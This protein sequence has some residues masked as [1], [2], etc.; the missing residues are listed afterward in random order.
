MQNLQHRKNKYVY[1]LTPVGMAK[2]IVSERQAGWFILLSRN[3]IQATALSLITTQLRP[4]PFVLDLP[5]MTMSPSRPRRFRQSSIFV[6]L[7]PLS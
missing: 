4:W 2:K 1:I 5:R 7:M 6:S 3:K